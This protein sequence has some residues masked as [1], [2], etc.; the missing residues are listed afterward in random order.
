MQH[1][2]FSY[3]TC[4]VLVLTH[5]MIRF[6]QIPSESLFLMEGKGLCKKLVSI[7]PHERRKASC[8]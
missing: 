8:N 1:A 7:Y 4:N 3:D 6:P 2:Y 5:G